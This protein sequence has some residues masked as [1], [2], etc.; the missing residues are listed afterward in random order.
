M[1][2]RPRIALAICLVLGL[3]RTDPAA[4]QTA[5][6]RTPAPAATAPVTNADPAAKTYEQC[7]ALARTD[8]QTGFET[9]SQWRDQGG[10]N[11]AKHCV[12]VALVNLKQYGE[13]AARLEQ[14]ARDLGTTAPAL[15]GDV[16]DQ[17]GQ[18]WNLAGEPTHA[19]ATLTQALALQ[20]GNP[21]ILIDR[22][23]VRAG[24]KQYRQAIDDLN[25]AIDHD[26]NRADAFVY[27]ATAYRFLDQL[28]PA[29]ADAELAVALGPTLPEAWL[30]RGNIRRLLH[31]DLGARTDWLRVLSLTPDGPVADAARDNIAKLDVKIEPQADVKPK[32][33]AKPKS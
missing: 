1:S 26:H 30:E 24:L 5:K 4:A 11:P 25:A 29:E 20:P 12:A 17:A 13:G 7:M 15:R 31:K 6:T 9:G 33:S 10:G 27:R 32:P 23:I 21:D 28:K 18:A 8:P 3:G 16:L 2:L 22:A 14:L 19:Q